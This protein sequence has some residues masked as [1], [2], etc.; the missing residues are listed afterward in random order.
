MKK[1]KNISWSWRICFICCF[2]IGLKQSIILLM[3]RKKGKPRKIPIIENQFRD[4]RLIWD[5]K[6]GIPWKKG[7]ISGKWFGPGMI[8]LMDEF[9]RRTWKGLG[10]IALIFLIFLVNGL[11]RNILQEKS[12]KAVLCFR[13]V[14]PSPGGFSTDRY[15]FKGE[16]EA[17]NIEI[18]LFRNNIV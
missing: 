16:G 10:G 13:Q 14:S 8:I 9:S 1:P 18:F 4:V 3:F 17:K 11:Y 7:Y 12:L 2:F 15:F 5:L 6:H